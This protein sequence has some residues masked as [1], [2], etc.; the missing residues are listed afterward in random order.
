MAATMLG[1]CYFN[2]GNIDAAIENFEKGIALASD[3]HEKVDALYQLAGMFFE[4]K[5]YYKCV[6]KCDELLDLNRRYYAGY[7][8]RQRAFYELHM[9]QGVIDDYYNAT[10]I[11]AK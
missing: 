10:N 5:E 1:N 6:D 7:V 8:L 2:L 9:G 4:I 11:Y 3:A